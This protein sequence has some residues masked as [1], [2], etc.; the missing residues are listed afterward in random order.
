MIQAEVLAVEGL[1]D[2]EY[3]FGDFTKK[4]LGKQV[5]Q[6]CFEF[7]HGEEKVQTQPRR[8]EKGGNAAIVQLVNL[9]KSFIDAGRITVRAL[10]PA[11]ALR[12]DPLF[13]EGEALYHDVPL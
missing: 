4:I 3:R 5:F 6:V 8:A 1:Q 10:R 9:P 7:G 2:P 13:G 12:G 11:Y